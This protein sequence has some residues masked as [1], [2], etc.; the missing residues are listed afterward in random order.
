MSE[1]PSSSVLAHQD[2]LALIFSLLSP[3]K[4][5]GTGTLW[6][7]RSRRA[8]RKA[9]VSS[10]LACRILSHH[11]LNVLWKELDDIRPLLRVLPEYQCVESLF[12]CYSIYST[13][14]ELE[15]HAIGVLDASWF[16]PARTLG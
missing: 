1:S 9:L 8:C 2:I 4:L 10:A 7:N 11:A 16:D 6:T 5:S 12:V 15:T 14:F 3:S 13:E